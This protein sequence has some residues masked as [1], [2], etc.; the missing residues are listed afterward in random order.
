[1]INPEYLQKLKLFVFI[2]IYQ[3]VLFVLT[4]HVLYFLD[5]IFSQLLD[6]DTWGSHV[7]MNKMKYTWYF[8]AIVSTPVT[9]AA[10]IGKRNYFQYVSVLALILMECFILMYYHGF[11]YASSVRGFVV[12]TL[13]TLLVYFF[14]LGNYKKLLMR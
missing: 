13:T 12:L 4:V 1:M 5:E 9:L 7:Y 6:Y 11:R 2:L 3:W 14:T 10:L 8:M